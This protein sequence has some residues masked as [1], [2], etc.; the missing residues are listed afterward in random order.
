M[1]A[2][3]SAYPEISY[4]RL[5]IMMLACQSRYQHLQPPDMMFVVGLYMYITSTLH[6]Y[7]RALAKT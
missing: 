3:L 6:Q 5:A 1:M 7:V 4:W 2:E